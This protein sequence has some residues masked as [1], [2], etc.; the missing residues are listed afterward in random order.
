MPEANKVPEVG[1]ISHPEGY[2]W[3]KR[4]PKMFA[5]LL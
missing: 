3:Q 1:T 4:Y 5:T 2:R